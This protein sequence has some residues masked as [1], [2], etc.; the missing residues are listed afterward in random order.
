MRLLRRLFSRNT[1]RRLRT[2][3]RLAR[4]WRQ[5]A[6]ILR[7][8][9]P[10]EDAQGE[11]V[12]PYDAL[13]VNRMRDLVRVTGRIPVIG[14]GLALRLVGASYCEC[15]GRGWQCALHLGGTPRVNRAELRLYGARVLTGGDEDPADLRCVASTGG[16]LRCVP[17]RWP[18]GGDSTV[19]RVETGGDLPGD[20]AELLGQL[21]GLSGIVPPGA[22]VLLKPNFNSYHA[23]PASTS[24][25]MLS[26]IVDELQAAGAS[27]IALGE[28]SAI[29][30]G[31]TREVLG[32]TGVPEWACARDV[33]LRYFDEE[34]WC[35]CEVPGRHFREIIIPACLQEF[36]RIIYLLSAKTHH[37]AG[38][39]LGLKMTIGFMHP[40]ERVELHSDHLIGRIADASLAVRPDLAILDATKC[41]ISGGPAVGV[42][43]SSGTLLA[44][45]DLEALEQQGLALL[46][47]QGAIGLDTGQ[48]QLR[49]VLTLRNDADVK[50]ERRQEE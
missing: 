12:T 49:S 11:A 18:A 6:R 33:R 10:P 4:W 5:V 25:E 17:A 32:R 21:G 48:E 40:A 43:A 14:R 30:L 35:R 1:L 9:Q 3:L 50:R 38:V 15:A 42:V 47:E 8:I 39:S 45:R 44:S 28:C 19:A 46:D 2:A 26:A 23:P 29:A 36:D 37:Q 22:K 16:S 27:Q 20:V 41:F 7:G 13:L 34:R 24:L 31:R